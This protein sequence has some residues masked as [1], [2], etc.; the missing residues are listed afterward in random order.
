MKILFLTPQLPY[1]PRQ[2][3]TIR[4]YNLIRALAQKH[5]IDLFSFLAPGEIFDAD[6]HLAALC[7]R[8]ITAPQPVRSA[9][10]RIADTVTA[11]RPD[12]GLRL[13]SPGAYARL[14]ALLQEESYDLLQAEGIEMAAYGQFAVER[15]P[16]ARLVFDDH[17]AE[18]LLQQRSALVDLGNP[19]RWPAALYSLIQSAKLRR[20][21]QMVCSRSDAVVAVSEPDRSALVQLVPDRLI[22]VVPN[23]IDLDEFPY[24]PPALP[25]S[26]APTLVFTGKMDY[27]P[28][29][30]AILWFAQEVLPLIHR[31]R[32]E[33]CLQ[34]VGMNPHPRL[35]PLRQQTGVEIT[36]AVEDVRPYVYA[37]AV[38]VVPLR[39]GGGT[40]FKVLEALASGK[41]MVSTSLGVEGL[42]LQEDRELLIGD[43]PATF[44]NA[45][46][47][48]LEDQSNGG[49]LSDELT[50]AGRRFVESHFAWEQIVPRLERVYQ[51]AMR[52]EALA[53]P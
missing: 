53:S 38:Y 30:D 32:P 51:A 42:G 27:R 44:A 35:A 25:V 19:L 11:S 28:N 45:V 33:V 12:M 40:R 26:P 15:Q 34:V 52:Q 6:N 17:N 21:E 5:Q 50:A 7:G 31:E 22:D 36:G 24:P 43:D 10:R 16:R 9:S 47:R 48:L 14:L 18:Y 13:E 3:T 37:A 4:N 29:V 49:A 8:V 23:G 1:P 46:L 39:V 41:P 20:Y 2:G